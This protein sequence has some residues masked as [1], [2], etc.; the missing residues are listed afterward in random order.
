LQA[1]LKNPGV[2]QA[3]K[4]YQEA[5]AAIEEKVTARR[6]SSAP[7]RDNLFAR[8]LS[9]TSEYSQT[10]G[11]PIASTLRGSSKKQVPKLASVEEQSESEE[12]LHASISHEG[13]KSTLTSDQDVSDN[14]ERSADLN[15]KDTG[16]STPPKYFRVGS[17]APSNIY[18]DDQDDGPLMDFTRRLSSAALVLA[19]KGFPTPEGHDS[20]GAEEIPRPKPEA[21]TTAAAAE[22][23]LVSTL[24]DMMQRMTRDHKA[25]TEKTERLL[26]ANKIECQRLA[27]LI[28]TQPPSAP[29]APP[30][31]SHA[32]KAAMLEMAQ[33]LSAFGASDA[34]L[35]FK[36]YFHGD[37][38]LIS[39]LQKPS[40]AMRVPITSVRLEEPWTVEQERPDIFCS[41]KS[42]MQDR[43]RRTG[44]IPM[45]MEEMFYCLKADEARYVRAYQTSPLQIALPLGLLERQSLKSQYPLR[46]YLE[47]QLE[48]RLQQQRAQPEPQTVFLKA[49]IANRGVLGHLNIVAPEARDRQVSWQMDDVQMVGERR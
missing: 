7:L 26:V 42:L 11:L 32:E 5:Q 46:N 1:I 30:P 22:S 13:N 41:T 20:S 33:E 39:Q 9:Q 34:F 8:R 36:R 10:E 35:M 2:A 21:I 47:T 12:T 40:I 19:N 16:V 3:L 18:E 23:E 43:M 14:E 27:T 38:P 37:N 24:M 31:N 4:E 25:T 15:R 17:L 45:T 28:A 49:T 48:S 44:G 29:S 6:S